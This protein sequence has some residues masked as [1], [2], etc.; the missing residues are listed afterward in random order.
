MIDSSIVAK[1]EGIVGKDNVLTNKVDLVSYS[2]DATAD[3]PTQMP[4]VVVMPTSTEMVQQIVNL[5][6]TSKLAIY[7]RGAGTNLSGGTIPLKKGIVLSFQRMNKILDI[8]AAN[9]TAVVQPGVVI[10]TLNT[11]VAAHGLIYP[12]DP[13][14]VKT[15]TMGGSV[16]ENSGGLRGLKYGVTK[17]MSW[18]WKLFWPMA[19]K[20]AS[21]E[22]LL[23][24]LQLMTSPTSLLAQK[25]HLAL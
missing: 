24:T 21:A 18:V 14:T 5:A 16:A 22:K 8:D 17:T 12:P 11:A 19:R 1:L 9:L 2:Y 7:P 6:R 13:G 15:A 3:V 25:E 20:S 23:K 10:E 4:D